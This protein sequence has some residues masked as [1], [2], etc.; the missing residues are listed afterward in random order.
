MPC[1]SVDERDMAKREFHKEL[2]KEER[3]G[4]SLLETSMVEEEWKHIPRDCMRILLRF[5]SC[6]SS[7]DAVPSITATATTKYSYLEV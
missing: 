5:D 2:A 1:G 7:T 6:S 4:V 3:V